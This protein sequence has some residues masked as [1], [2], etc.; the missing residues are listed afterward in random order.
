MEKTEQFEKKTNNFMS[1]KNFFYEFKF[2][3]QKKLKLK[4]KIIYIIV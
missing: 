3:N 2:S 4:I 1:K